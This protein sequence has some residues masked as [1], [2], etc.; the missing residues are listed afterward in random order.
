MDTNIRQTSW[1]HQESIR[2][3][4][5]NENSKMILCASF[6]PYSSIVDSRSLNPVIKFEIGIPSWSCEWSKK[7]DNICYLGCRVSFFN[8]VFF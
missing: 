3:I 7:S 1:N 5:C 6:D 2:D 4:K 8:L